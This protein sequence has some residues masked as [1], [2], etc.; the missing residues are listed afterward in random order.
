MVTDYGDGVNPWL[1]VLAIL[2]GWVIGQTIVLIWLLVSDSRATRKG[3]GMVRSSEVARIR[4]LIEQG[5]FEE[6]E[7]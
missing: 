6:L 4:K 5:K 1:L 2:G 7:R 3:C